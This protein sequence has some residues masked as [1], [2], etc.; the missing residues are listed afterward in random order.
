MAAAGNGR[1]ETVRILLKN[2]A[3]INI[4]DHDGW[5]ALMF[6]AY[7]NRLEAAHILLQ[8]GA[9]RHLKNSVGRTALQI[10]KNRGHQDI[11]GLLVGIN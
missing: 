8:Q 10:A 9:N 11:V 6:S 2:G 7:M 1:A 4:N 3:K 5:T